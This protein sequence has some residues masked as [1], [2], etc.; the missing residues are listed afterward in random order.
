[1]DELGLGQG[2]SKRRSRG[3]ESEMS[4][5]ATTTTE[6]PAAASTEAAA[7]SREAKAVEYPEGHWITQTV[8]HGGVVRQ[9]TA[10]LHNHFRRRGDVLVTVDLVLYYKLCANTACQRPGVQV[11]FGVGRGGNRISCMVWEEGK[12]PDFVLVASPSTVENDSRRKA[13]E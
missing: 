11:T 7:A 6:L 10:A 1:M 5:T 12:A 13:R 8:W 4:V 3:F 9:A 2:T